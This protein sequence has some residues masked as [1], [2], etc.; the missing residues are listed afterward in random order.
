[1]AGIYRTRGDNL[2]WL[3]NFDGSIY[4]HNPNSLR[5]K[6]YTAGG[7]QTGGLPEGSIIS[8]A[9]DGQGS[10]W[11]GAS[12]TGLVALDIKSG[13]FRQYRPVQ[14]DLTAI[15]EL[16]VDAILPDGPDKLWL[17]SF[18]GVIS[19]FN[20]KSGQCLKHYRHEPG[21]PKS[22]TRSRRIK[23]LI[24]DRNQPHVIWVATM[25]GGLD[26]FDTEK[27]EFSH[28][29]H[30][31]GDP[32]S[33]GHPLVMGLWDD[34]E[35]RIWVATY[36][37]GLN[38]LDKKSGEF[39]Q[40]RHDPKDPHSIASDVLYEVIITRKGEIWTSGKGG[41]SKLDPATGKFHNFKKGA[42]LHS[43]TIT[44][45]LEDEGG[46]LWLGSIDAGVA[47]FDPQSGTV[48][49]FETSDGLPS[50]TIFALV[51]A[52]TAD[53]RIWFGSRGGFCAL[54]PSSIRT[55][56][57]PPAI[58]FTAFK[59]GGKDLELHK[60]PELVKD[61]HLDWR[62]NFFEFQFAAL[63]FASPAGNRYAYKLEGRDRDW[64]SSGAKPFGRYTGLADG[65]YTL[66]VKGGN[67]RGLWNQEGAKVR[68]VVQPPFWRTIWFYSA[69][70][71]MA[72]MALFSVGYY[73]RRLRREIHM[74]RRSEAALQASEEL[75]RHAFENASTGVSLVDASGKFLR[76]NRSFCSFM[77][78]GEDWFKGKDLYDITHPEDR[79][80][81]QFY[82]RKVGSGDL[83]GASF[84]K[85]YIHAGGQVIW[86]LVS[87]SLV[88]DQ[89]GQPLYYVA[90]I[91]D[92]TQ[93]KAMEEEKAILEAQLLQ[94]QKMQAVG[95]L[96]GGI[97]H[98]FNNILS[99]IMG[100]AEIALRKSR[101]G[102][103]PEGLSA[104]GPGLGRQGPGPGAADP[105][106]QP[107]EQ[108][109][110]PIPAAQRA[111]AGNRWPCCA[112]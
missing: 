25:G 100:Y 107:Q 101:Q 60:A 70:A 108:A 53:G 45:L 74:R 23:Y 103:S 63:D 104:Q 7:T 99:A 28:Y 55:G 30:R 20:T 56:V 31:P 46:Y 96:A 64:Y 61:I 1:V 42:P 110:P 37:G 78:Y 3:L 35:G 29:N 54:D 48:R 76:V 88:R 67:S 16:R 71:I 32:Q 79:D 17:G 93:R 77:G 18:D 59:Q 112:P 40:Y 26:R 51:R 86:G 36:G 95:T 68:I 82:L 8:M 11:L 6:A 85:R 22:L 109:A 41:I 24:K 2:L 94:S 90:Q 58:R 13:R 44:T 57:T 15:P 14:D 87:T 98:D 50:N 47:R 69:L 111:A 12:N 73:M 10:L 80:I 27:E 105:D 4:V 5:V 75:F 66:R 21:N 97:A 9:T 65:E 52:K 34:A 91:Q 102:E 83:A 106:L 89:D 33:L 72:V 62:M 81:S 38:V 49:V 39:K 92:I 43:N 19:L 84:E